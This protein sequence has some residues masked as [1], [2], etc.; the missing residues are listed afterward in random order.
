MSQSGSGS[1]RGEESY[2]V[3]IQNGLLSIAASL[4]SPQSSDKDNYGSGGSGYDTGNKSSSRDTGET[5]PNTVDTSLRV[6]SNTWLG[7][8]SAGKLMEK[9]G[10]MFHS[11]KLQEKGAEKRT[12]A[13][14]GSSGSGGYGG[15][16]NEGSYGSSGSGNEGSY[17]SGNQGSY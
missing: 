2:G 16:G 6:A 8:S 1:G 9:A 12:E 11:S 15:S 13:G 10:D 3:S 5:G 7:D 4:T 14:Y 17:G